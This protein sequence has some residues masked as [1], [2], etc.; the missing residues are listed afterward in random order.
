MYLTGKLFP[1]AENNQIGRVPKVRNSQRTGVFNTSGGTNDGAPL[2]EMTSLKSDS[3]SFRKVGPTLWHNDIIAASDSRRG[4]LHP[5]ALGLLFP[6]YTSVS[7]D[8]QW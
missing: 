8:I 3:L 5:Y 7:P 2:S 1:N 4:E 6:L